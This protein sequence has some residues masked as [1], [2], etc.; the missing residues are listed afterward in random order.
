MP[1]T[2][3]GT[4]DPTTTTTTK[5]QIHFLPSRSFYSREWKQLTEKI[6]NMIS[7]MG[8]KEGRKKI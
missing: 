2:V 6:K 3:L 8:K 7:V 1:V 4:E 5:T